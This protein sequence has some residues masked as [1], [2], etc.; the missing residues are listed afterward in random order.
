MKKIVSILVVAC[1]LIIVGCGEKKGETAGY[2]KEDFKKTEPPAGF[3]NNA[4]KGPASGPPAT[5]GN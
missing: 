2:T 4:P 3:I 1:A 5:G